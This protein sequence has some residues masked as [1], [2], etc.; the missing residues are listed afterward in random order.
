[1]ADVP[2]VTSISAMYT[3]NRAGGSQVQ[4]TST[5]L[6]DATAVMLGQRAAPTLNVDSDTQITFTL[7]GYCDDSHGSDFYVL[8]TTPDGTSERNYDVRVQYG[9]A[10]P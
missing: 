7:P 5:G 9:T 4:L 6:R 2:V 1:M 8:V 3:D 10:A